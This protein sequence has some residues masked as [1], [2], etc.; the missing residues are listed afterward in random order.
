MSMQGR[1]QVKKTWGGHARQARGARAYNGVYRWGSQWG[2]GQ[3]PW[4]GGQTPSPE[5]ENLLV[6]GAQRKKQI[7][8]ILRILQAPNHPTLQPPA[9]E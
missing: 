8:F 6:L 9:P 4:T 1:R 3:S 5:A 7:C 2:P